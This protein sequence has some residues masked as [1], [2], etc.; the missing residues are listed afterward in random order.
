MPTSM[1][2]FLACMSM[3]Q[4]AQRN[5]SLSRNQLLLKNGQSKCGM[6]KVMCCQSPSGRMCC[7]SAIHCRCLSVRS[8]C[9]LLTNSSG[10]KARMRAI[11]RTPEVAAYAHGAG[12]TGEHALD[13]EFGPVAYQMTIFVKE[14][15]PALIV[16]EKKLCRSRYVHN[17]E[18][19][20][21]R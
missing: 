19:K 3:A 18:Y 15:F 9:R 5:W 6:V 14:A 10:K 16:L 20:M 11:C 2:S 17:A 7:C 21:R 8:C 4:V 13:G 1:P 12:T